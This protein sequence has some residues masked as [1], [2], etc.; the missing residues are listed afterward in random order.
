MQLTNL[1]TQE[2]PFEREQLA[3]FEHI[4]ARIGELTDQLLADELEYER[5]VRQFVEAIKKWLRKRTKEAG[6][7]DVVLTAHGCE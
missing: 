1:A 2:L 6:M 3:L 5:L 4:H 7:V